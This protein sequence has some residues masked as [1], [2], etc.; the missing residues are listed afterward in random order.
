MLGNTRAGLAFMLGTNAPRE[1]PHVIR[2]RHLGEDGARRRGS[3]TPAGTSAVERAVRPVGPARRA[4]G[5]LLGLILCGGFRIIFL[6]WL[7]RCL[8]G[9]RGANAFNNDLDLTHCSRA[10]LHLDK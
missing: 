9:E 8:R 7:L 6:R 5:A 4:Y 1:Q 3:V 2:M 10:A